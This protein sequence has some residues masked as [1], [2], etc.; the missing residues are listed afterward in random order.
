MN[1]YFTML[2]GRG[3]RTARKRGPVA[4]RLQ[5]TNGTSTTGLHDLIVSAAHPVR[6]ALV[7]TSD[8]GCGGGPNRRPG[9]W[10]K[11]L[12]TNDS[13]ISWSGWIAQATFL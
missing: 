6:E 1:I 2:Y 11:P 3:L 7:R 12:P 10:S 13:L 9:K 5:G 4:G 8:L